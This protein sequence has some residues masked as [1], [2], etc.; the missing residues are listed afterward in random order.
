[1]GRPVVCGVKRQNYWE[2]R[3]GGGRAVGKGLRVGGDVWWSVV[4]G[5]KG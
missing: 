1:M 2:V 3:G 4:P 5:I